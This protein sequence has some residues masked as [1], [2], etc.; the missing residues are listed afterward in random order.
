MPA[1]REEISPDNL[2]VEYGGTFPTPEG[3]RIWTEDDWLQFDR[4]KCAPLVQRLMNSN[5]EMVGRAPILLNK[6]I[7]GS[8]TT[9]LEFTVGEE[10]FRWALDGTLLAKAGY[11]NFN[12]K[13]SMAIV[14]F[15][16]WF[17]KEPTLDFWIEFAPTK[18]ADQIAE[19]KPMVIREKVRLARHEDRKAEDGSVL[20]HRGELNIE[21]PGKIT[22]F[23]HNT[24][25][26][27][28]VNIAAAINRVPLDSP[29]TRIALPA[30]NDGG[31]GGGIEIPKIPVTLESKV[32]PR[33]AE[34]KV[35]A[36]AAPAPLRA[37]LQA[38]RPVERPRAEPYVGNDGENTLETED[39][40]YSPVS[41]RKVASAPLAP[42]ATAPQPT[43]VRAPVAQPQPQAA[44]KPAAVVANAAAPRQPDAASAASSSRAPLATQQVR[45]KI[46]KQRNHEVDDST[47]E[48]ESSEEDRHRRKK[49]RKKK[50]KSKKGHGH[51]KKHRRD[52]DEEGSDDSVE[53]PKPAAGPP[54]RPP[55]D[56]GQCNLEVCHI[57]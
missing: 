4:K 19:H 20:P 39:D 8:E 54:A 23:F 40:P 12:R 37:K 33:G 28:H 24:A 49:S 57:S 2:P 26:F 47:S 21:E 56:R 5:G 41:E 13:C 18:T 43:A 29:D 9:T 55:N 35:V 1:I 31:D 15:V 48:S 6:T 25:Y 53:D 16:F 10:D 36:A 44:P 34:E 11:N 7:S 17:E 45:K 52:R 27:A 22:L 3:L 32:A 38:L 46:E 14:E 30:L 42:A 50:K 51:K